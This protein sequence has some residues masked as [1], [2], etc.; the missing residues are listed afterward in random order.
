MVEN[1]I[2]DRFRRLHNNAEHREPGPVSEFFEAMLGATP[3]LL[4]LLEAGAMLRRVAVP[5]QPSGLKGEAA[6]RYDKAVAAL[7]NTSRILD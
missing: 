1:E 5:L 3:Q 7:H 6:R 4:D 2:I